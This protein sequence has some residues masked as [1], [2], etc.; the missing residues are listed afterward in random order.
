MRF[1]ASWRASLLAAMSVA[2]GLAG[3]S[4]PNR[5]ARYPDGALRVRYEE[6]GTF[7]TCLVASVT[8][9]GN[10]L[11]GERRLTEN[12]IRNDLKQAGRDET[13]VGDLKDY[14]AETDERLHLVTLTGQ[15]NDEAPTGLGYWLNQRGYPVICVINRDPEDA[16]FNH[17]VVV[18]GISPNPTGGS[19]DIVHYLDPSSVEPLHSTEAPVF[20]QVW[21]RCNHAMMI[22]VP[23]PAGRGNDLKRE[24]R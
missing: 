6:A 10:Y 21:A 15:L 11:L 9:A 18:I 24:T 2:A 17:A 13:R 22:V 23:P 7:S 19:A 8:M 12:R 3:C 20:E 4:G 14:L 16:A 5:V 1:Y